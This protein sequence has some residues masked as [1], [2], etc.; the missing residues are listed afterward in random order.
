MTKKNKYFRNKTIDF[1][2]ITLFSFRHSIGGYKLLDNDTSGFSDI[3]NDGAQL[4]F[5]NVHS[6]VM[7]S[8]YK[9]KDAIL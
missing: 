5:N 9:N 1:N 2:T 3:I 8:A 7:E 6:S 4:Y